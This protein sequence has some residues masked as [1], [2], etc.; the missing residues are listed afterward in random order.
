[1][2][3]LCRWGLGVDYPSQ[4]TSL[5]GRY[6]WQD[7]QETP[8][9]NVVSYTFDGGKAI[10]WEGLSCSCLPGGMPANVVFHGEKAVLAL[11]D[12]SYSI[13]TSDTRNGRE[14][15]KE[16]KKVPGKGGDQTHIVNFLSAIRGEAKLNSEIAEGHK[17][18]L[19]CHLGNI[20]YR[21][22]RVV[23]CEPKTGQIVNDKEAAALW[24]REYEKGWEP[25]V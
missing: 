23:R 22:R 6:K 24:S 19:L 9:T 13:H 1:M 25:K 7:D 14:M 12:G 11:N 18:T 21:T 8:D 5:G 16:T 15:G 10:S 20:A 17:S 3:D 4:V 2:I